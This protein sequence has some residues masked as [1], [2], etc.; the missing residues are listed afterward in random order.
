MEH[1]TIDISSLVFPARGLQV[2]LDREVARL[3]EMPVA[4]LNSAAE[5]NPERFSDDFRFRLTKAECKLEKIDF[6]E[7]NPPFAYSEAGISM[8]SSVVGSKSA[9][10]AS[11]GIMRS[12]AELRRFV[13]SNA[14]LFERVGALELKQLNYEKETDARLAELFKT[15]EEKRC[16]KPKQKI[17]FDGQI[18]DAYSF[19]V[20]MVSRAKEEIILVDGYVN[21]H[22]LDLLRNKAPEV[23][24]KILTLPSAKLSE[25]EI[26]K[27]NK[28][29]SG[30]SV[31][32]TTAFH[33]RFLIFDKKE[34]YH[35]GASLKDAGEKTFAIS[36][37]EGEVET[38]L[39]LNKIQEEVK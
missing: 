12:F 27:F 10:N 6:D 29:Y 32:K 30:L 3:F 16:G 17:F 35:I 19:L 4:E 34:F 39:L 7:E 33:D 28:E 18:Y 5:K 23:S 21:I 38:T 24:L 9:I 13:T 22:T 36:K 15:I 2:V 20:E 1:R 11:I 25:N 8:L 26:R 14:A 31:K 37:L